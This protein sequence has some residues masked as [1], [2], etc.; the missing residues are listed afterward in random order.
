[1]H[2][3]WQTWQATLI[4]QNYHID[5]CAVFG[6]HASGRLWC[7]FFGL[8]CWVGIH[9]AGI[10]RL[11]H[12]VDNAFNVSF[13]NHLTRYAPYNWHMPD[14]QAQFLLLLNKV[15]LPHKDK[16]QVYGVQ[17]EIIGLLVD[18]EKLSISMSA[19]AK[20]KLVGAIRDFVLNTPDN[21]HQ[22]S[23]CTWLRILGYANWVLNAFPILKPALNSSYNKV[24]GKSLLSQAVY[25]NKD[26]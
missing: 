16:K 17:L 22:Q 20:D 3:R 13:N 11:L 25:I 15:N 14:D 7:L 19:E 4:D 5:H 24:A 12:Y 21:K 23:L 26:M 1:M 10:D 18:A 6:N 9:E 2:L 8:V